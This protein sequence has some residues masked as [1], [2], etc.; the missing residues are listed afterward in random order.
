MGG[1]QGRGRVLGGVVEVPGYCRWPGST[2]TRVREWAREIFLSP[3]WTPKITKAIP[4]TFL[5]YRNLRGKETWGPEDL[6]GCGWS[7]RPPPHKHHPNPHL[8]VMETSRPFGSS[9]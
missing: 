7:R 5:P 9:M 4:S 1:A 8:A 6:S 2:I 3:S